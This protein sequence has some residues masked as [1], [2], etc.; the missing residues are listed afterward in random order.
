MTV[1][2]VGKLLGFAALYDS[3][4]V[5]VPDVMAW[6]RIIGDLPYRDAE[7]AV[8][9]YYAQSRERLMPADVCQ[10]VKRIRDARLDAA[11][12]LIPPPELLE[13]DVAYREWLR[14]ETRRIADGKPPLRAIG[15]AS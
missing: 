3:R 8:T 6:H 13:D 14:R 4:R 9:E 12:D 10:G 15:G 5:E 2:E 11:G 1:E 7:Q